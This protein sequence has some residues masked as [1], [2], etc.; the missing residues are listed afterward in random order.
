MNSSKNK[1]SN[2]S[3]PKQPTCGMYSAWWTSGNTLGDQEDLNEQKQEERERERER[4][5]DF[6]GGGL[7]GIVRGK[8]YRQF[9]E[10][11][12][13]IEEVAIKWIG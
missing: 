10:D 1:L 13:Q 5:R 9:L 6:L 8:S 7:L 4:E 2:I 3:Y 11:H 12:K